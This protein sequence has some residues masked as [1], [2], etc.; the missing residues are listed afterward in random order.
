MPKPDEPD[1]SRN[2][3]ITE[4]LMS[5]EKYQSPHLLII[6]KEFENMKKEQD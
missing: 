6:E 2:E 5:T 1:N 4:V 3:V